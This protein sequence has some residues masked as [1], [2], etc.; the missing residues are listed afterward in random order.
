MASMEEEVFTIM[1]EAMMDLKNRDNV[2]IIWLDANK[3]EEKQKQ[4]IDYLLK[5]NVDVIV[6]NPVNSNKSSKLVEKIQKAGIPVVSIDR[7]VENTNLSGYITADNFRV[8]TEQAKYLSEQI[9]HQGEIV[10]LKGDKENNVAYEITNGNKE[11]L[12]KELK[13]QIVAEKWHKG[14][15]PELAEITVRKALEE[16]PD[17]KGILANNSDMAM[18]AVKVLKEKKMIERIITVGA[19]ASKEACIAIA[20]GEHDADV[21][22]MPYILGLTTF[23]A[24]IMIARKKTWYYDQRIKSGE[25][26]IPVKITPVLLIDKYN[27]VALKD[28]W[29]EFD[30][31]I[32]KI[33]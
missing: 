10:V 2:E 3:K 6:I 11:V 17:I 12:K 5:Q 8:G 13:I 19:D 15:S 7:F 18:A 32:E 21:D 26:S 28:R 30:K 27:I 24:A 9:D 4:D 20:K 22:K 16:Y 29:K 23:K 33:K 14:W 31:Y 25:Y 1:K